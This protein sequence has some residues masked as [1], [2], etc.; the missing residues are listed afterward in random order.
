RAGNDLIDGRGG[1]DRVIYNNDPTTTSGIHVDMA[2]GIVTGDASIG[3]DTLHSIESIQG[4]NF[5]DV[6]DATN[7]GVSGANVGSFGTFNQFQGLGG[8]DTIIGNG[9]T[10]IMYLNAQAAVTVDFTTG[11]AHGTA[12]GDAAAVGNDTFSGVS[13]V[14]GSNSADTFIASSGS[15]TFDYSN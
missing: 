8:N 10:T 9:N 11:T 5:A 13:S 15:Q 4:T 14:F 1:T 3:T 6:Y 2:S 12:P 7:F